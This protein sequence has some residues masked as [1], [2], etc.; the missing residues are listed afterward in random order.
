VGIKRSSPTLIAAKE[1]LQKMN[2]DAESM[3]STGECTTGALSFRNAVA[4][5]SAIHDA[6]LNNRASVG[7]HYREDAV[8]SATETPSEKLRESQSAAA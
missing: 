4:T 3:C 1:R 5:A 2:A 7:T 8:A 6:A